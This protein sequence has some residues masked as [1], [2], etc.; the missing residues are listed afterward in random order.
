MSCCK[1]RRS[2][3]KSVTDFY[4][5]NPS[6]CHDCGGYGAVG[7]TY[8]SDT[9]LS[10]SDLCSSC[11]GSD[12]SLCGLCSKSL[13]DGERVCGCDYDVGINLDYDCGCWLGDLS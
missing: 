9:G 7:F 4:S 13:V 10:C 12:A 5:T 11:E 8:D 6:A 3:E 1:S 2:Y